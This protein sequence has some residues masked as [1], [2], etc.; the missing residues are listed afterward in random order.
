MFRAIRRVLPDIPVLQEG[1]RVPQRIDE[2]VLHAQL[3]T[4]EPLVLYLDSDGH[5]VRERLALTVGAG[6]GKRQE[7]CR[8]E[9]GCA[10]FGKHL[11]GHHPAELLALAEVAAVVLDVLEAELLG[12]CVFAQVLTLCANGVFSPE[13]VANDHIAPPASG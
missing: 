13:I 7:R 11:E 6:Q 5:R 10:S 9:V 1:Q 4:R 2:P 3:P 8:C 12:F